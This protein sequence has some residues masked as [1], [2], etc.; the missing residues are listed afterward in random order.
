MDCKCNECKGACE[1]KPGWFLPSEA[2]KVA[3]HL[4]IDLKELFD[5]RLVV[6]YW[7]G[8]GADGG[9]I[10]V[11]SPGIRGREPGQVLPF[12]PRGECVFYKDG[13]CEIHEVKPH[14]CRESMVCQ[15]G[16]EKL[17][18]YTAMAWREH[19]AQVEELLGDAPVAEG[20]L[21]D[22]LELMSD[23]AKW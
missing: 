21:F 10:Y 5:T 7:V 12:D 2:E 23:F 13:L 18:R 6:D 1:R 11:L 9:D 22:A 8:G 19:Q 3:A 14:E 15:P 16:G 4:K 17:H 20:G